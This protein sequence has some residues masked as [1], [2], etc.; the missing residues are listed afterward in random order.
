MRAALKVEVRK[1]KTCYCCVFRV[2]IPGKILPLFISRQNV[3][4][5]LV[6]IKKLPKNLGLCATARFD[7]SELAGLYIPSITK[8]VI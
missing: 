3:S 2:V 6:V 4:R 1:T 7:L 5:F 8:F